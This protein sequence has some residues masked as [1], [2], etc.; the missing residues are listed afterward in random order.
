[1]VRSNVF[2]EVEQQ[3]FLFIE[4]KVMDVSSLLVSKRKSFEYGLLVKKDLVNNSYEKE[5]DIVKEEFFEEKKK[6][7]KVSSILEGEDDEEEKVDVVGGVKLVFGLYQIFVGIQEEFN[8]RLE[9]LNMLFVRF[10]D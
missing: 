6:F 7:V 8:S 10:L 2:K 5:L 9:N 3:Y 4:K 1:M